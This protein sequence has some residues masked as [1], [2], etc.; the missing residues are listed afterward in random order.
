[1]GESEIRATLEDAGLTPIEAKIYSTLVETGPLLAGDISKK[2]GI[3]RRL[4]YDATERL[5]TKGLLGKITKNNRKYFEA[6]R[7]DRLVEMLDERKERLKETVEQLNIRWHTA[8]EHQETL[9][10]EGKQGLKTV[11]EDLLR[12]RKEILIV[13][14]GLKSYE[15]MNHYFKWYDERRKKLKIPVRIIFEET[16]RKS[17]PKVPLSQIKFLPEKYIGPT[18]IDIYGDNVALILWSEKPLALIMRN[19]EIADSYRNFF[20]LM[21]KTA[22]N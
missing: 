22:K 5:L 3:H 6:V 4:V 17:I 9:L 21:W 2:A 12:E 15:M 8:Q 7:P 14:T 16:S 13:G 19:K 18:A 1:M 10:Y 20:E 11:F